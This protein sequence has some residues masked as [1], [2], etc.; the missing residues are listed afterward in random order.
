M[1]KTVDKNRI[2]YIGRIEEL[3]GIDELLQAF[4]EC[5]QKNP[6]IKLTLVGGGPKT[7]W[8]INRSRDLGIEGRVEFLGPMSHA[9]AMAI[10][11]SSSFIVSPSHLEGFPN[12]VL[13]AMSIGVPVISSDVGSVSRHLI[14]NGESGLL[15]RPW[16]IE[17]LVSAMEA[18]INDPGLRDKLSKKGKEVAS[19]YT[20]E[21]MVRTTIAVYREALEIFSSKKIS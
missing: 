16:N 17:E 5:C 12:T 10:L 11:A 8:Y 19:E 6:D 4:G 13:E 20:E 3:K 18:L 9:D 1:N 15:F 21:R 7:P 14:K 2:V